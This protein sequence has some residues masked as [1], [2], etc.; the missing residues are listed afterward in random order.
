VS[1]TEFAVYH[2]HNPH[3]RKELETTKEHKGA[4][5]EEKTSFLGAP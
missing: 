2:N 5:G 4:E 3:E 1:D